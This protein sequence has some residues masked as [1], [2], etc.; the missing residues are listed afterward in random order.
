MA[1]SKAVRDSRIFRPDPDDRDRL[2]ESPQLVNQTREI[3]KQLGEVSYDVESLARS[4]R[5]PAGI[6][7]VP[8]FNGRDLDGWSAW[9]THGPQD[10]AE[11]KDIWSVRDGVIIGERGPS[12]LYSPRGDYKDFRVRAE[13]K[14]REGGNSGIFFRATKAT[15]YYP[16]GY[17]AHIR[18]DTQDPLPTGSLYIP[19][20]GG[21]PLGARRSPFGTWLVLEAEAI[22]DRI[23]IWVDGSLT[24]D[25]TDPK[26]AHESGHFAIQVYNRQTQ[27][28]VRKLEVLELDEAG[29]PLPG[30]RAAGS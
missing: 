26:K 9:G 25:W 12:Y 21:F 4:L 23:R 19:D 18:G 11:A 6:G 20:R 29:N 17:E 10:E 27:I 7:L 8:L 1:W 16:R 24:V 13:V 30:P 15:S 14:I 2:Q 5:E 28:Q 3:R 22:G